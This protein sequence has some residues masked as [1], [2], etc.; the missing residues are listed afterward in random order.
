LRESIYR[1]IAVL[2]VLAG[3]C[4]PSGSVM[5]AVSPSGT[6]AP[7]EG[8]FGREPDG[9]FRVVFAGPKGDAPTGAELSIVFSRA[10]RKLELA[11]NEATPPVKMSPAIAGRWQWVGTRALVFVPEKG[12]LPGATEI[13]VSVPAETR[14]L[15]GSTLGRAY[16]FALTT[17]RPKLVRSYPGTGA[18][19]LEPKAKLE[20]LYNQPIDPDALKKA[21]TLIATRGKKSWNLDFSVKRPN[22]AHGKRLLIAPVQPLPVHTAFAFH[23]TADLKGEE[24]PLPAGEPSVFS[25]ET[26][27]PLS[28]GR[29]SCNQDTPHGYCAP[30]SSLGIQF[31]NPVKFKDAKR[32]T[33]LGA[34]G[35][36]WDSWRDEDD[37][38]TFIDVSA[39]L[40]AG[41][42]YTLTIGA[43]LT[44]KY[45]QRLGK[46]HVENIK[47]DDAWP[48]VEVGV[49]GSTLEAKTARRISVGSVN[50][51]S[52]ELVTAP[53]APEDL[54]AQRATPD[55][56]YRAT[57]K[58]KS[59]KVRTI[60]PKSGLNVLAKEVV[61]PATVLPGSHRGA[62]AIGIH[63]VADRGRESRKQ[64]THF[65]KV[66]EV[67]DL[68]ISAKLSRQGSLVWVTRLS[69][70]AP[71]ANATVELHQKKHKKKAYTAD[72]RGIATIPAADLSLDFYRVD[73]ENAP[74]LVAKSGDDWAFRYTTDYVEA[75][76]YE[77]STDLSGR[78]QRYGMMFTERGIYRPGDS[79]EVKGIVRNEIQSG[80]SVPSGVPFELVLQAPSG[81][82]V[83]RIQLKTS[84]FGTFNA[85]LKIPR[86]GS[87]GSWSLHAN[88]LEKEVSIT[89]YFEV[90]EYR[91]AE[92]KVTAESDKPEYVRGDKANWTGHGDYL[93]GAPMSNAAVR[94]DVLRSQTYF[95][96]PGS[97]GFITSSSEIY[98]DYEEDSSSPTLKSEKGKLDAKGEVKLSLDLA[99]P[100]QRGPELVSFDAEVQDVSRQTI[101]GGTSAIVHPASFYVGIKQLDDYFL[102]APGKIAPKIVA[103]SPKGQKVAGQKVVVELVR[104]KWTV[105]RQD[106]GS[107]R[108]H[109]V[110]KAVDT[111]ITKCDVTTA[112][113]PVTCSLDVKEGGYYFLRAKATDQRKNPVEATQSFFGIGA[114]TAWWKDGDKQILEL[115]LNKKEYKVG[116][117]A[118]VLVKSPYPEAEALVTVERAG[119]YR[120]DRIKLKGPTPTVVVPISED[121]RP[122][123]FV[124]I[125]LVRGRSKAPPADAG[126][127]DV[128][129]P[130]YRA[131]Y[132]ELKIDPE[133]RRLAI[134]V[135][136]A[137]KELK[138]GDT[139]EVAVSVKDNAGKPKSAEVT[140]YAVD[141][142]VLTLIGYKTPDPI[143]V[144]TASRPL[145]VATLET[146]E[147]MAKL[148]LDL[149]NLLGLDK[150]AEGGGGGESTSA[151]RDFRQSAYFNPALM[152][153]ASGKATARFKLPDSLTTFRLMAVATSLDDRYGYGESRIV[154]SRRLM[155]RPALPR[156]L[157]AGDSLDAGVVVSGKAFGPAKVTVTANVSGI[158]LRGDKEK[159]IDLKRDESVE[160]RFPMLAKSAGKAKFRFDVR[161]EGERD[162][163]EVERDVSVP[164]VMESVALYGE[165]EKAAGEKLGD[166]TAIR[167]DV[168]KLEISVASTALVG[169]DAGAEQ[170][171]EYPYSCT[172][173]LS[174]RL[175]PLVPLRELSKAF[176]LELPKNT[177][178]FVDKTIADI[179]SR[180][181]SDG[182]FGMWPDS[183]ESSP[184]VSTYALWVL[185]LA[186]AKGA[187]IPV[188][189]LESA[190][191]YVRRYLE[192]VREDELY[193]ATSAFIVDVLAEGGSPDTGYMSR[194]YQKR[195]Q[196]PLFAKAFLL[197]A[198][199]ISKQKRDLVD[200]LA[201]EL[202][203]QLRISANSAFVNENLGDD[204]VVL[205]DSP[206]R[207]SAIVLRALL[208]AKPSHPLGSKLARGLLAARRGGTWRST[209]ETAFAL[210][211]LDAYQKA[212]ENVVPDYTAKVWF[213]GNELFKSEAHGRSTTADGHTIPTSKL[214]GKPGS[215][216]VFEKDGAGRLF[217]EA[218]LRYARKTLPATPLDR[219]FFVQKTLRAV[220]PEGLPDAIKTIP[221]LGASRFSGGDL[222]IA[223][224]VIVTP[225]PREFVVID[226]PLPAGMEAVDA[227]LSTTASW[228]RVAQS[229]A[230]PDPESCEDGD[231]YNEWEDEVA[232]QSAFLDSWFR[233]EIRDD[234]VVFFVDHMAA[235]M[236][237]YRYLARATTFGKFVVP[238]TKAEEMYTPEVFGRTGSVLVEVK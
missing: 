117:V 192:T 133:A 49:S 39:K 209:Q 206:A 54:L 196:L 42:K 109:S 106:T 72:A 116:D 115:A 37:F 30:G 230:N 148:G 182:G 26:Y 71:V 67:T 88:K 58:L 195:G 197:H 130:E 119:V 21:S 203:G 177:N 222:V 144:F 99:M 186:K 66:V 181:R 156:F 139:A 102:D 199:A 223:D 87:L 168:G 9:P 97:D 96:P 55:E 134:A 61:D 35:V 205:M 2:A 232:H 178:A 128:G 95:E 150:G 114:G 231:C 40:K 36:E 127:P 14:S 57:R 149:G 161:A 48:S 162:A 200:K 92:F 32:L 76:R 137:K 151:R 13:H 217:Y 17:P 78:Q 237:H 153:D 132:A 65:V 64:A 52:Y 233:R 112:P 219:G 103:F 204:Y 120:T 171:I 45:G 213:G 238:P 46:P 126:K 163:V 234:R 7:G 143:P 221:D 235:G 51:P 236:Y 107:E 29:I 44:D 105:A 173:Q 25:F 89:Q 180:Q 22:P 85:R 94:Y 194:L 227:N 202:D 38:V 157:R 73:P 16:E 50:V 81:D 220:T 74:V 201:S 41:Q 91:P 83:S 135:T 93:F 69:D 142:G 159:T 208:A 145:Q 226:D 214:G 60:K 100:G 104:R 86:S 123:A 98:N 175:L 193:L 140:L 124:S 138:P 19:G 11:G 207:S 34:E 228:L 113:A 75:W 169:L 1:L 172:E 141:E 3:A 23:T 63:Y 108:Y 56:H 122:N 5:P 167:K 216:L 183:P 110:S 185:Q 187:A 215:M 15:D 165:T 147:S 12:R 10:L 155:A 79:V 27:G 189:V 164:T 82:E 33:T 43:G 229:T 218:R 184:W 198:M 121:L 53:L 131:G 190:R 77:I 59:A 176:G 4:V 179:L 62:L 129:A 18:V 146:R 154:T 70:G 31:S 174:S 225:S 118:R 47:I 191:A 158:E 24:G 170:L 224:I 80:N 90:A 20:L 68:A 210:L 160:V 188:R 101:A 8:D 211:A 125:H 84:K 166:L 152:T 28:V 6:L 111:T 212:Q 136:P